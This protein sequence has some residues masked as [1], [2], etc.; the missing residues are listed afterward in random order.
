MRT[1]NNDDDGD[2][3]EGEVEEEDKRWEKSILMKII[4]F[5]LYILIEFL[6]QRR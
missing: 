1:N 3:D 6:A 4:S 2:D 5:R